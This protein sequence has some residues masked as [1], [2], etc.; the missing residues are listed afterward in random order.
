MLAGYRLPRLT[1]Y[2]GY[3]IKLV[4]EWVTAND[5]Y[6]LWIISLKTAALHQQTL[7]W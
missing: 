3:V 5:K 4:A 1:T 2:Y 6:G 7:S